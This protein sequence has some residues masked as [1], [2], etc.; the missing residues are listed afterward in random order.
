MDIGVDSFRCS[1]YG[2][3]STQEQ[4]G[5]TALALGVCGQVVSIRG[6]LVVPPLQR[7]DLNISA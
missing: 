2:R 3:L 1:E 4:I 6:R 7:D 5:T